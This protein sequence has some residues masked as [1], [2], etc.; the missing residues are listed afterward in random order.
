MAG[1]AVLR[2]QVVLSRCNTRGNSGSAAGYCLDL[3]RK[4]DYEGFL[5]TLLLPPGSQTSAFAL[6]ALNVELSQVKDSVSQRNLGL[7]RMQFWRDAVQEIYSGNTPH[8]PVAL[9]L[10]KAVQ[11]HKLTK[12]WLTRIVDERENNLDNRAYGSLKDLETYAEN[13]QSSLLYLILETLDVRDVHSD[14]AASHIGKAHGIITCLR[15]VPYH[16]SRRQVF[17][18]VDICMLHGT[19]QEDF[20]RCSQEKN[21]KDVIFDVASQAHVHLEHA[22]SFKRKVQG[23][24]FAA[25]NIT[26]ALDSYLKKLRKA[27]FN[28]F[29]PSLQRKNTLLPLYFYVRSWKKTY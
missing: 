9:E 13:T 17:L 4:R 24:A 5:C 19:S 14:H 27:D 7:M 23:K 8:H 2:V 11:K 12:R 3:V 26:V 6:R 16:S 28:I 18:P 20:I 15:A 29:H 22:R 10:S 21:V 25:F 1:R